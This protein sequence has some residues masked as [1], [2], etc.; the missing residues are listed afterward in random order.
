MTSCQRVKK[1]VLE[2]LE[3]RLSKHV[4]TNKCLTQFVGTQVRSTG[5]SEMP[6]LQI[7]SGGTMCH[8][9]SFK[10][11]S[12]IKIEKLLVSDGYKDK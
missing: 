6:T 12:Q 10:Y 2:T 8:V 4:A 7:L 9:V 1:L 3:N 5:M 11:S